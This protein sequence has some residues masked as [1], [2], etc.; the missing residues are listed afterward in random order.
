MYL[1]PWSGRE[2][3]T[4]LEV[5]GRELKREIYSFSKTIHTPIKKSDI[6][7]QFM[8]TSRGDVRVDVTWC[9]L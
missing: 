3:K 1:R 8:L 9:K 6:E 4:S 7:P 2:V 5:F